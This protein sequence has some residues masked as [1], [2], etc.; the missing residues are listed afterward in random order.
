MADFTPSD[1]SSYRVIDAPLTSERPKGTVTIEGAE[2]L[3]VVRVPAS[4]L[5]A[6]EDRWET[7]APIVQ[8]WQV[9]NV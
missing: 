5:S 8:L 6:E 2:A 9:R 7:M 1:A 3:A 4:P